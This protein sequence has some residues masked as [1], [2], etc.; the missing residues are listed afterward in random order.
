MSFIPKNESR[1]L[2]N[3]FEALMAASVVFTKHALVKYSSG[4]MTNA[5]SGDNE[6]EYLAMETKTDA[7]ASNGGTKGLVVPIDD[8]TQFIAL[9]S[10][11][12][13]Q[14]THVGNNYDI[15]AADTV[16]LGNTTDKVFHI[17]YILDAANYLVVGRF[18][19]PSID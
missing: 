9:C 3:A 14:A 19:K 4:Y 6:V 2:D 12:P 17:D 5:A 1:F 8:R 16:D 10:T 11:T 13:V 18:N 7:T 15:S